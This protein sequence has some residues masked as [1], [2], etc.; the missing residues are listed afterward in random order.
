MRPLAAH[1]HLLSEALFGIGGQNHDLYDV[2]SYLQL[3]SGIRSVEFNTWE[4][5]PHAGVCESADDYR[6][7]Q[8]KLWSSL[9]CRLS[10]F[11]FTWAAIEAYKD[12][13][14]FVEP[15][16][17]AGKR[18]R[19]IDK[20]CYFLSTRYNLSLPA[21]FT[22][23][24]DVFRRVAS[25]AGIGRGAAVSTKL[26]N[27]MHTAGEGLYLVYEYRNAFAHGDFSAPFPAGDPKKHPDVMVIALATRIVLLSLQM[28]TLCHYPHEETVELPSLSLDCDEGD[29]P[30]VRDA[31]LNLHMRSFDGILEGA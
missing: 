10:V 2:T 14:T 8:D 20:L 6:D 27:Y 31:F 18:T 26:P 24:L 21:K 19:Q 16:K 28:I 15:P 22:E 25:H 29:L 23:L 3:A 17:E 7:A 9:T 11:L 5:E 12:K 1:A 30:T 4:F 13:L